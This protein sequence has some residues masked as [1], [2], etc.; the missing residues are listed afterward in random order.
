[1]KKTIIL[2]LVLAML[3]TLLSG[4]VAMAEKTGAQEEKT[5]EVNEEK[6]EEKKEDKKTD[7]EDS[8]DWVR[9]LGKEKK[10][11][12]LF[13]VAAVG[14]TTAYV[15]MHE[16]DK[17]GN[18][19][20]IMSTPGFIG[21]FGL[22]KEKE[23]DGK[24]PVG[25]FLFNAAFGIAEDPGCALDYLR[26]TENEYWSGDQR[27]GYHYNEMIS[28]EDL[29]DLNKDDSEHIIDYDREYQYCLNISYNEKGK[30]GLGSA[31]FLHCFGDIKP[32]TGGCVAIP[33]DMMITVMQNVRKD[34]VVV[35]DSLKEISPETW[36]SLKLEPVEDPEGPEID[37]GESE[38]F[39][40]E[41]MDAAI[42]LI[43][44]EFDGWEGCELHSICYAGDES[45]SRRNLQWLR[46]LRPEREFTQCISFK[47]DFHSPVET[48]GA[49]EADQEYTEWEWWLARPENGDWEL[50]T[51]GY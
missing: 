13:V 34:C 27:E 44:S 6:S 20:Q 39:E 40:Q 7:L 28:I 30:P 25:T 16:K 36:D 29:P 37:Y 1:M 33:Q 35:I 3:F 41:D 49:W 10:A 18:W 19:K 31:I 4:T 48:T 45:N 14:Q 42:E 22:G 23:G 21:K 46:S 17:S 8:P 47:S 50:V 5:E 51:W 15:S 2:I 11:K 24:T 26:V 43:R 9:S 12:Q 32:Y 38:L